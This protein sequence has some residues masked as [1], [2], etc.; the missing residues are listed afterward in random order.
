MN[1]TQTD[2]ENSKREERS[3]ARRRRQEREAHAWA[4]AL[5][6]AAREA[7]A[8]GEPGVTAGIPTHL[9]L[10]S[11][12]AREVTGNASEFGLQAVLDADGLRDLPGGTELCT[13]DLRLLTVHRMDPDDVDNL[14]DLHSDQMVVGR[15]PDSAYPL[16]IW[17]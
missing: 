2:I 16:T 1:P 17:A 13:N 14:L 10:R 9:W 6:S 15:L 11:L 4:A 7:L 12:A 8:S 3:R 5:L